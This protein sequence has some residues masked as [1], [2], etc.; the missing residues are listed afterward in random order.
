[1]ISKEKN[2]VKV[3]RKI[4]AMNESAAKLL[5]EIAVKSVKERNRFLLCL[6]GGNTPKGLYTLLSGNP[7]RDLIPWKNT[8]VFWSDERCV[9]ADD[10]RNNAFMATEILLKK[11]DIPS[12][13]IFPIPVHLQPSDAA[14]KYEQ[15]LRDFFGIKPPG[16]D[17]I[18]LGLGENGHTASLF[19]GTKVLSEK[20]RWVKEVFIEELQMYRIT[21]TAQLINKAHN[22]F[23]LITGEE[24]S[25]ILKTVLTVPCQPEK[26]PVQL[27]RPENGKIFWFI[28]DKA[29]TRLPN[30]IL[31]F[32]F[33]K[34][35][36]I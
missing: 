28:D 29:A 24:K 21:F 7:Y 34:G 11:I 14:S 19:P 17:L 6:S 22:I 3:F 35:K 2:K 4:E 12:S 20:S 18:L 36:E 33:E 32:Q 5:V 26:Y 13:N 10:K 9:P 15:T 25:G 23:F 30:E 1:M 31:N 8:L 16:F 27:I